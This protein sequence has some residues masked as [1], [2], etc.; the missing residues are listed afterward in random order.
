MD[1]LSGVALLVLGVFVFYYVIRLAVR[2]GIR[3][4]RETEGASTAKDD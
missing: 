4:A 3:A 2:D 1:G